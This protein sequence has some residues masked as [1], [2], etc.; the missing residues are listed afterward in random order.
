MHVV[1]LEQ[2]GRF[3]VGTPVELRLQPRKRQPATELD[4]A[5][6]KEMRTFR[7]PV[8][9]LQAVHALRS[10]AGPDRLTAQA[11]VGDELAVTLDVDTAQIVDHAPTTPDEHQQAATAVVIFRVD[12]EMLGEVQNPIGQQRDLNLW[13]ARVAVFGAVLRNDL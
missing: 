2:L 9:I 1:D 3:P 5:Q 6:F 4:A 7:I 11:E 10:D 12:L 13:R 8:C